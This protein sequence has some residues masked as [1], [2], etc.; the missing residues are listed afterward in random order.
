MTRQKYINNMLLIVQYSER[1]Y[2]MYYE[3]DQLQKQSCLGLSN[4][5]THHFTQHVICK[6]YA[7][8]GFEQVF[9]MQISIC[10]FIAIF[11]LDGKELHSKHYHLLAGDLR[12]I[13]TLETKLH[14]IGVDK[15]LVKQN[16]SGCQNFS[17]ISCK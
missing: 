15:R 8:G 14:E 17:S 10:F 11:S 9:E 2:V 16:I 6:N 12:D 1:C 13:N 5:L 3:S 4:N 7:S